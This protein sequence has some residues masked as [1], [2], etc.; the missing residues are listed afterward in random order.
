MIDLPQDYGHTRLTL[1]EVDPYHLYAYWELSAEDWDRG[2][3]A[4]ASWFLRFYENG[5]FFDVP[6]D[7][8]CPHRYLELPGDDRGYAA[9]IGVKGADG[10]FHALC[11]S[12]DV[13]LPRATPSK[14]YEP[15]WTSASEEPPAE[16]V[17][18]A[19]PLETP[20]PDFGLSSGG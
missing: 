3:G 2:G 16:D 18:P 14:R 17:A 4:A 7:P 6:I 13:Q 12:N 11:R 20:A 15:Q 1:M 5:D 10:H 9:E 19:L 8:S